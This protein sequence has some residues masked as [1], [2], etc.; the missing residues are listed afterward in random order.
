MFLIISK[1]IKVKGKF[2]VHEISQLSFEFFFYSGKY[3]NELHL[4]MHEEM[5]VILSELLR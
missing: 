1:A 5:H 3:F 2:F 4:E